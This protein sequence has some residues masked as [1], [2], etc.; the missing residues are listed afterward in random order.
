MTGPFDA[1]LLGYPWRNPDGRVDA[2]QQAVQAC[3]AEGELQGL[4]RSAIF[5]RVWRLAHGALDIDAP[6]LVPDELG[7]PGARLSEPWYCCAEPT[8]QQLRSF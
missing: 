1:Q 7:L 5:A 8:A 3:V 2:L 6:P 4:P